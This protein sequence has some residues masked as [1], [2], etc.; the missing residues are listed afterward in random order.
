MLGES[1]AG[2]RAREC[3]HPQ[4]ERTEESLGGALPLQKRKMQHQ[5]KEERGSKDAN[6]K[7][8]TEVAVT[9]TGER[10]DFRNIGEN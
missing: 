3:P 8:E 1:E 9:D 6:R 5:E 7:T 4:Q 10:D 2:G